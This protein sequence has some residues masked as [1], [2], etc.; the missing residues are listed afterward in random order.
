MAAADITPI[1]FEVT[2]RRPQTPL[3]VRLL[4]AVLPVLTFAGCA[5]AVVDL[6]L[7][8]LLLYW[9]AGMLVAGV[10]YAFRPRSPRSCS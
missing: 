9:P 7:L 2:P 3:P 4:L 5:G 1:S 6:P 8:S 10:A